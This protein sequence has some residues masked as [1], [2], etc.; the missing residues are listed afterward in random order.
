MIPTFIEYLKTIGLTEP[1]QERI[2]TIYD[3][4]KGVCPEDITDIFV[5]DY[6]KE[7]GTREYVDVRFL[8]QK[9]TMIAANFINTDDFRIG[10]LPHVDRI[11]VQKSNYDFKK[12]TE[13]SRMSVR[14]D[15]ADKTLSDFR[16][17][18]ENCDYLRDLIW[19]R[20]FSRWT[21]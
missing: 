7:D 12:A 4:F 6:I 15:Y 10:L 14:V 16:A 1:L 20:F 13:K 17:S 3:F 9:F 18:K 8:S 19:K 2:E 21:K 11:T 5:N